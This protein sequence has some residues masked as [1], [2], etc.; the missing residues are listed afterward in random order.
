[1][2]TVCAV[3]APRLV[4]RQGNA[5]RGLGRLPA[6]TRRRYILLPM[7]DLIALYG[8]LMRGLSPPEAPATDGLLAYVGPCRLSGALRDHGA[9]PGLFPDEPGA[10]RAELHRILDTRALDLLDD[11]EDYF[12]D[13]E[14]GSMYLRRRLRLLA[15]DVTAWVYVSN[16]PKH[17]PPVPHGCWRTR[18]VDREG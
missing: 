7:T 12:E 1:M 3:L 13:D 5:S 2:R 11:W 10:V 17:D 14:P 18:I 4:P 6:S 15:P 9:Y 8:S 16:L